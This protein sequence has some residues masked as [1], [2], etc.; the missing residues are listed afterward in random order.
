MKT[1]KRTPHTMT[2]PLAGRLLLRSPRSTLELARLARREAILDALG[3]FPHL[4]DGLTAAGL[5]WPACKAMCG[6]RGFAAALRDNP[7]T[8]AAV[9]VAVGQ[10]P[11]IPRQGTP[12]LV[13]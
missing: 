13:P 11:P 9:G 2:N 12:E 10:A 3:R 6:H 8:F 1:K 5:Y 4:R 7:P